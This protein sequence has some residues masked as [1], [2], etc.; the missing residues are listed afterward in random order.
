MRLSTT[1]MFQHGHCSICAVDKHGWRGAFWSP[2]E[3][4]Y[5]RLL[6]EYHRDTVAWKV[7][8]LATVNVKDSRL[9]TNKKV[10]RAEGGSC[11]FFYYSLL[12]AAEELTMNAKRHIAGSFPPLDSPQSR[13][14]EK[15]PGA[16]RNL[17]GRIPFFRRSPCLWSRRRSSSRFPCP[18]LRGDN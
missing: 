10:A 16:F 14:V 6:I 3:R 11:H 1:V 7:G 15:C 5:I 17:S 18:A 2:A 12:A 9:K 4:G 8:L 13:R